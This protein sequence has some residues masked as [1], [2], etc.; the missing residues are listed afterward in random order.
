M[1]WRI[2]FALISLTALGALLYLRQS[3][4]NRGA[5]VIGEPLNTE[6]GYVAIHGN[7]IE[8]GDNGHPLYRLD[9]D[10]IEQPTPQ[11]TIYLTQPAI[12]YQPDPGDHWTVT[13]LQGELPQDARSADLTGNV[14]AEGRP[15]GSDDLM[16]IDTDVL[17]LDM[18]QQLVTTPARVRV[19]WKN[20]TLRGRGMRAELKNNRLQLYAD[21]RGTTSTT[22]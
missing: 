22:R 5:F 14:H 17:H 11:G 20:S 13:A 12:D 16:R 21:V 2:L 6:P 10:R 3:D 8:T 4:D 18:P 19:N 7:L 1:I 9:A 15:P